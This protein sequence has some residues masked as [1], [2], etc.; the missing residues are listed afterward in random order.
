MMQTAPLGEQ[1]TT[2]VADADS[3][4]YYPAYD[5]P[6]LDVLKQTPQATV[7]ESN[8]MQLLMVQ[9]AHGGLT[10]GDTHEYAEPFGFDVQSDPYDYL[11]DSRRGAA[12][13]E[14]AAD[15]TPLG[16]GL[17][18]GDTPGEVVVRRQPCPQCAPVT[19][20]GGRGMTMSPAI[21]ETT[22]TEAGL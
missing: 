7:A 20:P 6:A 11:Q 22:Y 2:A 14:N 3:F 8:A 18:P 21:A 4:R 16:R 5:G 15:R 9:R 17:L 10:I 1:L 19:G 12:R 13:A